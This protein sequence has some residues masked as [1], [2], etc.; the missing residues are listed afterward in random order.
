MA[1]RFHAK[2]TELAEDMLLDEYEL[3]ARAVR[4][5]AEDVLGTV[6]PVSRPQTSRGSESCGGVS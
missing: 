3:W 2:M 4:L 5:V 6:Q 1:G